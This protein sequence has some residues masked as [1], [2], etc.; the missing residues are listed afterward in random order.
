M[1]AAW[2]ATESGFQAK[3]VVLTPASTSARLPPAA[4]VRIAVIADD[5]S[6]API[7][8]LPPSVIA[9]V[10]CSRMRMVVP[11]RARRDRSGHFP[12]VPGRPR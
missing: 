1:T 3:V 11:R 6:S 5:A 10:A 4:T 12:R 8:G 9:S 7:S 2:S